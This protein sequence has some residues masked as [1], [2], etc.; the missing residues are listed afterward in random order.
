M[1]L[2]SNEAVI[3]TKESGEKIDSTKVSNEDGKVD[4]GEVFC[5]SPRF[6]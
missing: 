4:R 1:V 3:F 6:L 2:P 5:S